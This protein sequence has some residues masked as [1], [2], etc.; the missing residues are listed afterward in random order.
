MRKKI[1]DDTIS[2]LVNSDIVTFYDEVSKEFGLEVSKSAIYDC[3]KIL[4]AH[5]IIEKWERLFI[6]R[7]GETQ[8]ETLFAILCIYGPKEYPNLKDDEVEIQDGFID[9]ED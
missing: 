6:D 2:S 1:S 4:I 5:N 9:Y 8:V 3:R 7:Y